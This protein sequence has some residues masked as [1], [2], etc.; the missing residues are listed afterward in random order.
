VP[1]LTDDQRLAWLRLVRSE[2]VGPRTFFYLFNRFGSADAALS[3][4]PDLARRA[5][6]SRQHRI[7]SIETARR[8]LDAI[9]YAGARLIAFGEPDYPAL[10][11]EIYDPPPVIT[12]AGNLTVLARADLAIVGARNA[13]ALG[14][15]FAGRIARDLAA[16]GAAIVSGLARGIDAAAHKATL[17]TGTVAVLAGGLNRIYPTEN[18]PLADAIRERGALVAESPMDFAPRGIDFP[19]RNRIVAGLSR[20]VVVI[21]AAERSGSLITARLALDG[22]REVFAAPGF[23]LDPRSAGCNRLIRDGAA[24]LLTEAAEIVAVLTTA[25]QSPPRAA[26]QAPPLP[27]FDDGPAG[28]PSADSY[29]RLLELLGPTPTPLDD[30]VRAAGLPAS[31]VRGALIDLVL[32]GRV[33]DRGPAGMALPFSG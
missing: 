18:Q 11:R 14:I 27:A 24:H 25:T 5:G 26:V 21:E 9:A 4:L 29:A 6:G 15:T 30:L 28:D 2:N 10:L 31:L 32:A 23:P 8:E 22:G 1:N 16:T 12:V 7:C 33:I 13:S 19:R 17:E 3:A 20:A